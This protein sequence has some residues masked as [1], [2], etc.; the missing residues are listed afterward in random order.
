MSENPLG[1]NNSYSQ[2][3]PY[4]PEL[5]FAIP[6]SENRKNLNLEGSESFIGC[7]RW[8]AYEFSYLDAASKPVSAHLQIDIPCDSKNI[9]E[10]KSLKLYLNSLSFKSFDNIESVKSTLKKD[11]DK[12]AESSLGIKITRLD[13][14]SQQPFS[15]FKSLGLCIDYYNVNSKINFEEVNA[16]LLSLEKDIIKGSSSIIIQETL[17]SH[18]F[19]SLCPVTGQPDWA[20]IIIT[21]HGEAIN[22]SALLAYLLSYRK[23]QGFHEDCA[24][25]I[26]CDIQNICQPDK[27]SIYA[28]FTRRGGIDINPF[29]SN[30]ETRIPFG[31]LARQ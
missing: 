1:N 17:S 20:S 12:V 21:Y 18:L 7:D 19:R 29:R 8:N 22:H 26:F 3:Q 2:E 6:R 9:I 28:A 4:T 27:L 16:N 11:L 10:S 25:R 13:D 24:E 23:H 14:L 30:Y 31:R 15:S 5:L